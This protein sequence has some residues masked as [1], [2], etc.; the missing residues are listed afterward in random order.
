MCYFGI[1]PVKESSGKKNWVHWQA[2][3]EGGFPSV[4]NWRGGVAPFSYAKPLWS[5]QIR[6]DITV[7]GH[8][9][10]IECNEPKAI[11]IPLPCDRLPSS[12]F[13]SYFTAGKIMK[14]MTKPNMLQLYGAK[15][16]L[17]SNC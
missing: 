7:P 1:A 8:K 4:G 12:G 11:R 13:A 16:H 9:L 6:A 2:S 14:P 10:T 3:P 17:S 5:G 15:A